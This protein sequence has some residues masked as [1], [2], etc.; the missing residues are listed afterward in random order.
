MGRVGSLDA[1]PV[2]RLVDRVKAALSLAHVLVA[3]AV[4]REITRAA[5]C[6]GSGGNLLPD[7][8]EA[9]AQLFLTGELRHHDAL[10][11]VAAGLTVVCT[12][13]SASER[14][15]LEGL[16]RRLAAGLTGVTIT[17]SRP[18]SRTVR[19]RVTTRL[20]GPGDVEVP[21]HVVRAHDLHARLRT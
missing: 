4:N 12:L 11:A 5:V 17:R 14:A 19:L 6:A 20:L 9:G 15:A 18:G 1:A 13:H 3:G 21:V 7:A 16:E 2:A 8:I 10:R